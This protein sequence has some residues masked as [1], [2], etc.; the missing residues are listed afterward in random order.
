MPRR[1]IHLE[2]KY[3]TIAWEISAS[4][5]IQRAKGAAKCLRQGLIEDRFENLDLCLE[6]FQLGL[7]L[8]IGAQTRAQHEYPKKSTKGPTE[9]LSHGFLTDDSCPNSDRP[10]FFPMNR[11]RPIANRLHAAVPVATEPSEI[12]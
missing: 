3:D 5:T 11:A 12:P 10:R 9:K 2:S 7:A 4:R 8:R 1:K 6:L